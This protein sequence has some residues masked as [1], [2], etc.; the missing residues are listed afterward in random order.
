M[1]S[2]QFVD[3]QPV[4][5]PVGCS[6]QRLRAL[7]SQLAIRVWLREHAHIDR[8]ILSVES[9]KGVVNMQRSSIENQ[10]GAIAIDI[11]QQ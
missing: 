1:N 11:V 6:E 4:W 9:Q 2:L 5:A 8:S 10:K 7:C 3:T